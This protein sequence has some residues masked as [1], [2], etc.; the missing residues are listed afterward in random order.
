VRHEQRGRAGV[1]QNQLDLAPEVAAERRVEVRERL[2]QQ[3]DLRL[4]RERARERDPLALAPRQLVR[5]AVGLVLEAHQ[6]ERPARE[7]VALVASAARQPERDVRL[8]LQVREERVVL[9][10]HPGPA[11]LR[12]REPAGPR[13][14]LAADRDRA[15]VGP[16]EPGD[17]AQ[18]RRLAAA[19]R[20]EHRDQLAGR[21]V[22]LDAGDRSR[23]AE[24]LRDALEPDAHRAR[25]APGR[26]PRESRIIRITG[27]RPASTIS[28]AGS[29]AV[30]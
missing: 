1:A 30:R 2:V 26:A 4:G 13:H 6:L 14:E 5:V 29:A 16:L 9:E 7:P 25:S 19:G 20:A 24:R 11:P 27:S 3:H 15:G 17:Q 8:H 28:S 22:E 18:Q 23:R 10:H 21:D 12:R